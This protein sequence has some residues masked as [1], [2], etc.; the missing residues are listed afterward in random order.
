MGSNAPV[1]IIHSHS[2][3]AAID[4]CLIDDHGKPLDMGIHPKDWMG[5]KDGLLSLT[6]SNII[7]D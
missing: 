4:V 1:K 5:D 6:N 3:G 2:T 7:S